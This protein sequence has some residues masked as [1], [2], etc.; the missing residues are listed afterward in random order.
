MAGKASVPGA[1]VAGR[2]LAAKTASAARVSPV[3]AAAE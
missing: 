2:T 1:R 3:S